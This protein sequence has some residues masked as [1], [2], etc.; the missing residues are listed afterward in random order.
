MNRW[1]GAVGVA[2]VG[3]ARLAWAGIGS[4]AV[5]SGPSPHAGDLIEVAVYLD[6][7]PANPYDPAVVD[8]GAEVAGPDGTR[9]IDAFWF[10]DYQAVP[11]ESGEV[12]VPAG[13]PHFRIR[14]RPEV[15]GHY[16][17]TVHATDAS[18]TGLA[19]PVGMDVGPAPFR[20]FVRRVPGTARL[21]WSSG[22]PFVPFGLN[23]GWVGPGGT[24]D[25]A[26]YFAKMAKWGLNWSRVWMTHFDATALEWSSGDDGAYC[27]VGCYNL[28]A[29]WRV[30][31]ILDSAAQNGVAVQLVLQ[32]HSQFETGMWSSW[33]QNPWN[34]AN[35][36]PLQ[37]SAEFF[38]DPGTIEGFDRRLRYLVARYAH[39]PG[40][41]A[42]E[43]WNEMDLIEGTNPQ[44]VAEWC[45]QRAMRLRSLD[46]YH[47]PVTTS[48]AEPGFEG[49]KQD[50]A[51][52]GYDLVQL[53]T[54]LPMYWETLELAA[55]FLTR[56]GKPVIVAEFGIDFLGE[57]NQK[58][59]LGVHLHNA[60]LL[61]SLSG[62]AGGAMSWWWDTY[63]DERDLWGS[64]AGPAQAL[65]AAGVEGFSSALE[66]ATADADALVVRAAA[67]DAPDGSR[68]AIAWV[69]DRRSE[70]DQPDW[71]PEPW[72][73]VRLALPLPCDVASVRFF[74]TWTGAPVGTA[75]TI[76]PDQG[77]FAAD[78]P[79]FERDL[80]VRW[81][82]EQQPA[83]STLADEPVPADPAA[84]VPSSPKDANAPDGPRTDV[85][86]LAPDP[87]VPD[88]SSGA[89]RRRSGGCRAVF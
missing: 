9:R 50:W 42:W 2:V 40:L 43:L 79:A 80:L 65:L 75:A 3:F 10:Q 53:H 70:W 7:S 20:G 15:P 26:Y 29:A 51:F 22:E 27:G 83:D 84:D 82:C 1:S 4:L 28:K 5:V 23:L 63:V 86:D 36:G 24:A 13:D 30:D 73:G 85:S 81:T 58:D 60:Q 11:G 32:Q 48:Y 88:D 8:V 67:S 72:T 87:G 89:A 52:D 41:L 21:A 49:S 16:T 39:S 45:R 18:G 59:P 33:A 47:R 25:Y 19:D 64:I 46:P 35:G 37:S 77:T 55:A 38:T 69:H 56:F 14:F 6:H 76:H 31:R 66:G 34:A 61:A 71:T 54:Y 78:L 57:Q 68:G 44:V 17:F 74:D 62:F 12:L